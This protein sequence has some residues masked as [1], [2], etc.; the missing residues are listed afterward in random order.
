MIPRTSARFALL[1]EELKHNN[2]LRQ[3]K[4]KRL[5]SLW[6]KKPDPRS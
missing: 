3:C 1:S 5:S 6:E 2:P 4:N